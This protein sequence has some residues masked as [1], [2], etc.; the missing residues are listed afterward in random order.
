M[1]N[2]T[3]FGIFFALLA[4]LW[5]AR[6]IDNYGKERR[7]WKRYCKA[8]VAYYGRR[9]A[10]WY[11]TDKENAEKKATMD[12]DQYN[13]WVKREKSWIGWMDEDRFAE[14]MASS[15]LKENRY[16]G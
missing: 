15:G 9:I 8:Q 4:A 14:D 5:V 6:Q 11:D 10:M 3:F 13:Y 7:L 12:V 1:N 2:V 16:K